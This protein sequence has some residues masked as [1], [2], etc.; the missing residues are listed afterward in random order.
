MI[1]NF[2]GFGFI[3]SIGVPELVLIA[4][5]A[6][7]IFGPG[8]LPEVGKAVGKSLAEFRNAQKGTEEKIA[9]ITDIKK[10]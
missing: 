6:L 8:K 3:P 10:V 4:G 2:A 1:N 5:I 9:E 7:V